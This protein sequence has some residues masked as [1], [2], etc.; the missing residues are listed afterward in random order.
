M[1]EWPADPRLDA[2]LRELVS[3]ELA[4]ARADA[5]GPA[6]NSRH[7]RR[8]ITPRFQRTAL[9]GVG[10]LVVVALGG[11]LALREVHDPSPALGLA[12]PTA[13]PSEQ[14]SGQ[15][16]A[17]PSLPA[18]TPNPTAP[19]I[20]GPT[21]PA[22]STTEIPK[23]W[24]PPL[25]TQSP[26]PWF[27][28]TGSMSTAQSMSVLLE[29]GRV[30]FIGGFDPAAS[31]LGAAEVYDPATG[32][33]SPTG[34]LITPRMSETVT[35]LQD[36]RV[37]VVGGLTSDNRNDLAS[38]E[39]YDP[40]TGKFSA[41][42]S[43]HEGRQFHTATLLGDGRVLIAGGYNVNAT[44]SR[45]SVGAQVEADYRPRPAGPTDQPL[46]MTDD[47]A[48]LSNCEIYDPKT[49]EFSLAGYLTVA[50]SN[51]TAT[52]L[53]DGRVFMYG[54]MTV[55]PT[56]EIYDP[57][58]GKSSRTG[59]SKYGRWL[60]TATLLQDGRVLVAGGRAGDDSI[61]A[62]AEIY[63][64]RTGKF[65]TTGSM[66]ATRQEY[67][68]TL[69]PDGR[70]LIAGGYSGTGRNVQAT[71]SVELFDPKTGK[72]TPAGTM[73]TSRMDQTATLLTNGEVLIAGGTYIAST[74]WEPIHSAELYRP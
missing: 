67:T 34:S 39:I 37:L 18:A 6:P 32:K 8:G 64:P 38:A 25:S 56:A 58:T 66:K 41:T 65:T 46:W 27:Q 43:L 35:R 24:A 73:T 7:S 15:S 28:V 49:G 72:F 36:G 48:T 29:D 19:Q 59:S 40:A 26:S 22:P 44:V 30:L 51:H 3:T 52:L 17:K 68:A 20:P 54:G 23:D 4:A 14:P 12:S 71:S 74:G 1:D 63:D 33:F 9:A 13:T 69:L 42:G 21:L 2:G 50:R 10:L 57:K 5:V 16:S 47:K 70:V 62:S 60:H 45:K 61:Y 11:S 53:T 31:L 55:T